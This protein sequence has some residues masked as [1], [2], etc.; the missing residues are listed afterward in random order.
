MYVKTPIISSALLTMFL[1]ISLQVFAQFGQRQIIDSNNIAITHTVCGDMNN[2]GLED[3]VISQKASANDRISVYYNQGQ[4]NFGPRVPIFTHTGRNSTRAINIGDLNN[5]G[6]LDIVFSGQNSDSIVGYVLNNNGTFSGAITLD[7]F[8]APLECKIEDIDNDGDNDIVALGDPQ[9]LHT[10]YNDGNLSFTKVKHPL[11]PYA[12][13]Y[14]DFDLSD[15][16][17]DGFSDVIVAGVGLFVFM[18][19]SGTLALDIDRTD[20]LQAVVGAG[21]QFLVNLEDLNGDD[22][23]DLVINGNSSLSLLAYQ[24]SGNGYFSPLSTI[25]PSAIQLKFN[26][27]LVEDV[28][29]D[30][31]SVVVAVHPYASNRIVCYFNDGTGT[32]TQAQIVHIGS[33][34]AGDVCTTVAL[35]DLDMDGQKDLVWSYKLSVHKNTTPTSTTSIEKPK[36]QW[37]FYP[38]PVKDVLHIRS[39][40]LISKVQVFDLKG[41]EIFSNKGNLHNPTV[42]CSSLEAGIYMLSVTMEHEVVTEKFSVQ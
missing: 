5:D 29:N 8:A 4:G 6:W 31:A 30:Q 15:I 40:R 36:V 39:E 28:N 14:Y 19:D 35:A 23:N 7:S 25:D 34:A 42:D 10:Y 33:F 21:L 22:H 20:S 18:N 11:I 41:Q 2:D 24:N 9:V 26:G 32:F 12:T 38:N 27:V 17:A 37:S 1:L 13:E 3:I 16:D